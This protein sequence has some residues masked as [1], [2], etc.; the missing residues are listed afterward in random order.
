MDE[1][2]IDTN[3]SPSTLRKVISEIRS[4]GRSYDD[5]QRFL[6]HR[7]DLWKRNLQLQEKHN[8]FDQFI[9]RELEETM[10]YERER[11]NFKK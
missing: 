7:A 2:N 3:V 9:V 4:L 5:I 11:G 10:H 1:K 8:T 6:T